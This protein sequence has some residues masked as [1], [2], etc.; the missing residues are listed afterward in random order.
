MR[1]ETDRPLKQDV[2]L[3]A[4]KGIQS[5]HSSQSFTAIKSKSD[6]FNLMIE[7]YEEPVPDN[8]TP[9][10]HSES[11]IVQT[12]KQRLPKRYELWEGQT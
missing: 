5:N 8:I 1:F 6:M 2:E 4:E 12:T 9:T 3:L 10:D 7:K 11:E